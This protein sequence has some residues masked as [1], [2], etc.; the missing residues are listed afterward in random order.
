MAIWDDI[1]TEQDKQVFEKAH[2]GSKK[3]EFG[4]KPALIIIDA[5][6]NF[7]GEPKPVLKSIEHFPLS[8]G[9]NAWK[10]VYQIASLL[11]L[12]RERKIPVIYGKPQRR[13]PSLPRM[14]TTK[15]TRDVGV[16]EEMG[17][18][19]VREIA[20]TDSD[21][22][23]PKAGPSIFFGTYILSVLIALEIDTLLFCG[24]T[25]SGCLRASVVD[26]ASYGYR[27]GVI[28]EGVFDRVE[29]SHKLSLFEMN[30]KYAKVVSI[31]EVKDYL[32]S[33]V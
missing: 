27:V 2:F 20:P 26:A 28:E 1:V 5:T 23:I 31:A 7:V 4:K 3:I 22:V 25:T 9:E 18:E 21:I 32:T 17:Y 14:W 13:G 19:I 8:C 10:A 30:A 24:G 11:P 12:A 33:K 6:Y 16:V 29:I 15:F